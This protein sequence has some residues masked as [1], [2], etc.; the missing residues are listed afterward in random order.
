[1]GTRSTTKIYD[2]T[3]SRFKVNNRNVLNLYKQHDGYTDSWGAE[4]KKFLESGKFVNGISGNKKQFNGIEDFALQLVNEYKK[5]AG[6]LYATDE[7]DKQ[8]Y[9]YTIT[10]ITN[11]IEGIEQVVIEC[12]EDD[13][14]LEV[15]D[16]TRKEV[17]DEV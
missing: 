4:L 17:M 3:I 10:F 16:V 7:Q 15:I 14:F 12:D 9:N 1:M 2:V 13:D 8:E 5:G 11:Y 6:E